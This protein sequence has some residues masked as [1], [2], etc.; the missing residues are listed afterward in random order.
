[1]SDNDRRF[2]AQ[3]DDFLK[4]G[5]QCTDK[6]RGNRDEIDVWPCAAPAVVETFTINGEW[7]PRCERHR[8]DD[9]ARTR[10]L[11]MTTPRP[12]EVVDLRTC[13]ESGCEAGAHRCGPTP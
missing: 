2:I 3:P 4:P 7:E 9:P 6:V 8:Y 10:P 12:I 13:V 11:G 5:E 1:M